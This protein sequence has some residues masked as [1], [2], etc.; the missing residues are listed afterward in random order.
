M[1]KRNVSTFKDVFQR[2]LQLL[3][4]KRKHCNPQD[5]YEQPE[6]NL[7]GIALSGGGIR[8]ATIN[9]GILEIFNKVGI[10]SKAD[11]LSTVS[12]GGYIGGYIH[13]K[14]WQ[15]DAEKSQNSKYAPPQES[16]TRLFEE[17]DIQHLK[18]Y[19][20]YLI[21][22]QGKQKMLSLFRFLGAGVF[23]VILNGLWMV[24]LVLSVF[25][26]LWKLS[27]I[28]FQFPFFKY[29]LGITTVTVIAIHLF[30]YGL[31]HFKIRTKKLWS[32]NFLNTLEGWLL[33]F[34]LAYLIGLIPPP[35]FLHWFFK[36]ETTSTY[37]T[38]WNF[39]AAVVLCLV[40]GW[41][42]NPNILSLHRFYRDRLAEAYLGAV[43]DVENA[44]TLAQLDQDKEGNSRR[45]TAP[46]PLINT[47]VNL[48]GAND[49]QFKGTKSSDYFLLSPLFCGSKLT[50]Y[51]ETPCDAYRKMTLATAI[52]VSG[53][54]VN[55]VMGRLT[56]FILAFFMA[57]LNF[58]LG[59]WAV[60]PQYAHRSRMFTW[61]PQF[62]LLE[63]FSKTDTK[64]VK[65]NISDGGHIENLAVYELLRRRCKLIV[66]IDAGAD[67]AYQFADLK[68]LVIR[69]K[70]E[71]NI[72][73]TFRE[74]PELQ[75]SPKSSQ[76]FSNAHCAIADIEE[77][78]Q[79]MGGKRKKVGLLVYIKS[80]LREPH[81]KKVKDEIFQSSFGDSFFYKTYHPQF[82]HE[83]TGDQFFDKAQWEAYYYLG[84]FIASDILRLDVTKEE[85]K[86]DLT[87]PVDTI[88]SLYKAFSKGTFSKES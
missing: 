19:G 61:W 2:E 21:P 84:N 67:P 31:R 20:H 65:V 18:E 23:N 51:I 88:N 42:S 3:S 76:G 72:A 62:L 35:Y 78:P 82:P 70:N 69:A 14:L 25:F 48:Q 74:E 60:N 10:L 26:P 66:A 16:Y 40:I 15:R 71:L 54:A 59:Y 81:R 50:G 36:A 44:P 38:L 29:I 57:L 13:A 56:N 47:C 27:N 39:I 11:Y 77:L 73:I 52:A 58:K 75:I 33:P 30:L 17:K 80:S 86:H 85:L 68:N 37:P 7:F 4:A 12:G 1:V 32:S 28:L 63:L 41:F 34:A 46:Y 43:E 5:G 87:I 79:E 22:G 83:T 49:D 53:A 24:F 45:W 8:S 6:K 64:K 9:L 55:P